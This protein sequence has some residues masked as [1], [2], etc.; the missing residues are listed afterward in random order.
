MNLALAGLIDQSSPQAPLPPQ[1]QAQ[2]RRKER[3]CKRR[4]INIERISHTGVPSATPFQGCIRAVTGRLTACS[5]DTDTAAPITHHWRPPATA[6][7]PN[8]AVWA[9][10]K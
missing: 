5:L 9:R 4:Q 2:K 7:D 10:R 8:P 6:T 3:A 1:R